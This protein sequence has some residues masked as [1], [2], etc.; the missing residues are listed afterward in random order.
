M[1]ALIHSISMPHLFLLVGG[2]NKSHRGYVFFLGEISNATYMD[3]SMINSYS[4][5]STWKEKMWG[6]SPSKKFYI[7]QYCKD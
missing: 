7:I 4:F 1:V 5:I 6:K 3:K 2:A